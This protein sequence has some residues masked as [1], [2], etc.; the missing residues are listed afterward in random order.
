MLSNITLFFIW[1]VIYNDY[2]KCV[3]LSLKILK[4]ISNALNIAHTD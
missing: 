4:I 2:E 1:Y 3:W